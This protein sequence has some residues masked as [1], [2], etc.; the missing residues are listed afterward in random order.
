MERGKQIR[1]GEWRGAFGGRGGGVYKLGG[2]GNG[3]LSGII[4][5]ALARST[6]K[7]SFG[8][9]QRIPCAP[10]RETGH[11][12]ERS[13]RHPGASGQVTLQN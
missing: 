13:G 2:G 1:E 3:L 4:P 10:M 12:C 8:I 6:V 11:H 7:S 9:R 5:G